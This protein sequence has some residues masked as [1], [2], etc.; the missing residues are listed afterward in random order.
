MVRAAPVSTLWISTSAPGSTAPEGSCT[1]PCKLAPTVWA[2]TTPSAK[3]QITATLNSIFTDHLPLR[4]SVSLSA[5]GFSKALGRL[6][7]ITAHKGLSLGAAR[8]GAT[9]KLQELIREPP[10]DLLLR[11]KEAFSVWQYSSNAL[12][13][14]V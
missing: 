12:G 8:D 10:L 5:N 2:N 9:P 6:H 3:Q 7:H 4:E 1:V 13:S 11:V 14:L